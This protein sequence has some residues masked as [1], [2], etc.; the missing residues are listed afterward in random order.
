MYCTANDTIDRAHCLF[1]AAVGCSP[2]AAAEEEASAAAAGLGGGVLNLWHGKQLGSTN[3]TKHA[4]HMKSPKC[5][6][7]CV[8]VAAKGFGKIFG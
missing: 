2:A 8:V 5:H 4:C 3:A 7:R 1:D 6:Y